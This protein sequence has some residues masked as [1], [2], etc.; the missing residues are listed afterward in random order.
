MEEWKSYSYSVHIIRRVWSEY[1]V[2]TGLVKP[3]QDVTERE[4]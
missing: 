3:N 2:L 4:I 1:A